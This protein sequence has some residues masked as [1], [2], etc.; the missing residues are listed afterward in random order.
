MPEPEALSH[1]VSVNTRLFVFDHHREAKLR[2]GL[3]NKDCPSGRL[4]EVKSEGLIPFFTPQAAWVVSPLP[5]PHVG[6]KYVL[7]NIQRLEEGHS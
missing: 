1:R 3:K 4:C 2:V 7:V 6:L 5:P